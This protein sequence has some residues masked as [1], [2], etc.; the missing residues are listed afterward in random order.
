MTTDERLAKMEQELARAKR[1]SRWVLAVAGVVAGAAAL[2]IIAD[3]GGITQALTFSDARH[4]EDSPAAAKGEAPTLNI[5]SQALK[6]EEKAR[7]QPA[8]TAPRDSFIR[9]RGFVL[10]DENGKERASLA[11]R[12][13]GPILHLYN[14]KG[15]PRVA[16]GGAEEGGGGY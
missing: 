4:G 12:K 6:D 8:R 10:V 11:M 16:L 9:A 15:K 2:C 1:R 13:G 5:F 3:T 14:E 7:K